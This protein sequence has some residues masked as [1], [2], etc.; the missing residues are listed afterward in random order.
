MTLILTIHL[1]LTALAIILGA[2]VPLLGADK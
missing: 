2:F 1:T